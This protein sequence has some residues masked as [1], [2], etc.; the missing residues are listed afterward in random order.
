[1]SIKSFALR[2]GRRNVHD[3]AALK[4]A[5]KG[6]LQF[7]QVI[8]VG[9]DP[10]ARLADYHGRERDRLR[11]Q[12][13]CAAREHTA[14]VARIQSTRQGESSGNVDDDA[15]VAPTLG[16]DDSKLHVL[17]S[18]RLVPNSADFSKGTA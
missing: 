12:I 9:S 13:D 11:R 14:V 7:A 17:R 4:H 18:H 10:I 6:P 2:V 5:H 8:D 3:E 1:L 16:K 15:N